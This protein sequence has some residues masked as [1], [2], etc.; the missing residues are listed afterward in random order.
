MV[1]LWVAHVALQTTP[2]ACMAA[3][4]PDTAAVRVYSSPDTNTVLACAK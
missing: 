1:G 2:P 4:L 3:L